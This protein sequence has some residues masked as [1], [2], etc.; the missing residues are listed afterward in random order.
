M[1]CSGRNCSGAHGLVDQEWAAAVDY[2]DFICCHETALC[3]PQI[4]HLTAQAKL[5]YVASRL[6]LDRD[7][8]RRALDRLPVPE[9]VP[10]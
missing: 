5:D 1:N 9:P 6:G 3:V 4:A 2:D 8:V 10:G 7:E